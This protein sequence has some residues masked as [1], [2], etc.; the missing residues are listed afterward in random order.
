MAVVSPIENR[1]A[2]I[3]HVLKMMT[4][5]INISAFLKERK[6]E[7]RKMEGREGREGRERERGIDREL[8]GFGWRSKLFYKNES[9][10][11]LALVVCLLFSL[12]FLEKEMHIKAKS[13]KS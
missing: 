4:I 5:C 10:S 9:K 3:V 1:A 2:L 6:K 12:G 7:E 11:L 8:G 13:L